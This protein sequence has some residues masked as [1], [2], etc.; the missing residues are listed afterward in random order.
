MTY[1]KGGGIFKATAMAIIHKCMCAPTN[2][3]PGGTGILIA[4]FQTRWF[5]YSTNQTRRLVA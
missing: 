2:P 5:L 4:I 3:E 1:T